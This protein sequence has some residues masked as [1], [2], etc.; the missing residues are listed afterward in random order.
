MCVVS[1]VVL[2]RPLVAVNLGFFGRLSS[3]IDRCC[4]DCDP[5]CGE[6]MGAQLSPPLQKLA[7]RLRSRPTPAEP[8]DQLRRDHLLVEQAL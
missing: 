7:E 5:G 3:D 8:V 4:R 1:F 2:R 6:F